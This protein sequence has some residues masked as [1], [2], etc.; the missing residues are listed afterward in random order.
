VEEEDACNA[1]FPVPAVP[2]TM[3]GMPATRTGMPATL[4]LQ[5]LRCLWRR[6]G[7]LQPMFSRACVEFRWVWAPLEPKLLFF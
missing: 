3:T 5:C 1:C 4:V 7:C 2:A 6:Q